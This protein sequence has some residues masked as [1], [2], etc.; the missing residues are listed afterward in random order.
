[1]FECLKNKKPNLDIFTIN[2]NS[3]SIHNNN[4]HCKILISDKEYMISASDFIKWLSIF[5]N[6]TVPNIPNTNIKINKE[7]RMKCYEIAKMFN[8][9]LLL[10]DRDLKRCL[11]K[12]WE[13]EMYRQNPELNIRN[14]YK[15]INI[16]EK[17]LELELE[18][19]ENIEKE[20]IRIK[21][22]NLK[23]RILDIQKNVK[24]DILFK[25]V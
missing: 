21:I 6:T 12:V 25:R 14:C 18:F 5:D 20:N 2:I 10:P 9:N 24:K 3:C 23:F 13:D 17:E 4:D 22:D 15:K 11:A 19:N 8:H 16:L 7:Y 1:M